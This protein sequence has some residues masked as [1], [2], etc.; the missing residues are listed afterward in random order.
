MQRETLL[1]YINKDG[2]CVHTFGVFI[3]QEQVRHQI[4]VETFD[5]TRVFNG[6]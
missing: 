6:P 1:E 3:A 5:I 2:G 4:S